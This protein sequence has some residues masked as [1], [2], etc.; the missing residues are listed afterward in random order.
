[1]L[2]LAGVAIQMTLGEN[3]LFA[4]A[5]NSKKEQSKSELY[6]TAKIEYLNLKTKAIEEGRQDPPISEVLSTTNFLSKYNV[7]GGNITDKKGEVIDTRDNLLD[8]LDGMSSSDVPITPSA[9]TYPTQSY[10]KTVDGVTIQEQDKD[11]LILKI[12]IKEQTKLAIRPNTY[13]PDPYNI[14]VEWGNWGYNS[15]KPE[16]NQQSEH[17]YYPGE[18]TMKITG[19]KSFSLES[20][21]WRYDKFEVTVLHW[22]KFE[23]DSNEQNNI[24]LYSVKDI[25]MPEPNNVTVEY[26]QATIANIPEDLFKYKPT[27]KNMSCFQ[28]CS[29]ITSV[30]SNLYKYNTGMTTLNNAFINCYSITNIPEGLFKYNQNLTSIYGLFSNSQITTIPENLFKFNKELITVSNLF[31][32]SRITSIPEN[33]F[34]YNI[35]LQTINSLF[36]GSGNITNVPENLFKYNTEVIGFNNVFNSLPNLENIPENLFSNNKKVTNFNQAFMYNPKLKEIPENIFKNNT[37]ATNFSGTFQGCSL[38]TTIPGN[39]FDNNPDAKRFDNT[40]SSC[41]K[42]NNIPWNLFGNNNKADEFRGTFSG[43]NELYYLSLP[44]R[45]Y[46]LQESQYR[47]IFA[48]CTNAS[49][50]SS[51]PDSWKSW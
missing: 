1:M 14:Q 40:F 32:N 7:D 5:T 11:K 36:S 17:E 12:K 28:S 2:L 19:A 18:F 51:I 24:R 43:P 27:R 31:G 6:E 38:I 39:L 30:P 35:K 49:N 44:N 9:Q 21:E 10:P 4:K 26:N 34:K 33:L 48:G 41:S 50:Y 15:F 47:G 37:K 29:N 20:T 16:Y 13:I 23:D 46:S 25:K 8:K 3:G 45:L 42:L 22:G